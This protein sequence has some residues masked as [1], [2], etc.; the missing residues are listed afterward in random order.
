LARV[1]K[2]CRKAILVSR[3]I[4][5]KTVAAMHMEHAETFAEALDMAD[6]TLGY[7]SEIVI[8]PDGVGVI[9]K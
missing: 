1:L 9:V 5:K 3:D 6:E 7:K 8:I 4:D 2:K